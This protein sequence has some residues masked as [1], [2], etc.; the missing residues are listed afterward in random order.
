METTKSIESPPRPWGNGVEIDSPTESIKTQNMHFLYNRAE[1]GHR[2]LLLL[3]QKGI[4]MS[5][6]GK[7][8]HGS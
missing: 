6:S 7:S 8:S 1:A 2:V 5:P 4:C 3:K